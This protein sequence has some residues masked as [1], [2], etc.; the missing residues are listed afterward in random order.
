MARTAPT[1]YER[2][3]WERGL[4]KVV[5]VD[6]AG[7]GPLAGPV[8]AAAVA[9]RPG[10]NIEGVYDSKTLSRMQREELAREI[11]E[12]V[13]AFSIA[14]ASSREIDRFNIRRATSLAM[15]RAVQR[16]PFEPE[17]LL[18]DGRRVPELGDHAAIV[19]GDRLSLSIACASILSKTVRDCLM[20]RLSTRYPAYGWDENKGYGTG[21]H[22]AA[23]REYG[24]TPH[25]RCTWAPIAQPELPLEV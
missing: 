16:L 22:L 25:H 13:F 10:Q 14:A 15:R 11:R 3:A 5:G 9:L 23:I 7:C 1:D 21:R 24:P 8:V 4:E 19:R 12:R 17:L 20:E 6:E 2:E 18:V